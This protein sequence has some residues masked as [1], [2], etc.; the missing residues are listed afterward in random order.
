MRYLYGW[1][2]FLWAVHKVRTKRHGAGPMPWGNALRMGAATR[3][4][5][6]GQHRRPTR[7]SKRC[8]KNIRAFWR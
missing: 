2:M 3:F 5:V 8:S 4:I 7:S 6:D 1:L